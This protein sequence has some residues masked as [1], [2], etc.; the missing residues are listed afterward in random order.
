MYMV[1]QY[2]SIRCPNSR[3]HLGFQTCGSLL[4]AVKEGKLYL[5]CPHCHQF[6][7]I[8]IVDNDNIEMTPLPQNIKLF[9]Q[10]NLRVVL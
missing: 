4:G 5:R 3:E 9:L 10:S 8:K 1:P 6:F 7:E 2:K